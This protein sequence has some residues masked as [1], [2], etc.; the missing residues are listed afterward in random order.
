MPQVQ[1][2]KKRAWGVKT[3][4]GK[5]ATGEESVQRIRGEKGQKLCSTST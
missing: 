2:E 4:S 1:H 3:I 5:M